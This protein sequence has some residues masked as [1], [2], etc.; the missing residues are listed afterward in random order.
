MT[1]K[2]TIIAYFI[3]IAVFILGVFSLYNNLKP[4]LDEA[5]YAIEKGTTLVLEKGLKKELL[6]ERL[7][8]SGYISDRKDAKFI[9]ARI[10]KYLDIHGE[11][12]NLGS[13]LKDDL[14][15]S[16]DTALLFGGEGLKLRIENDYKNLGITKDYE[17]APK[18]PKFEVKGADGVICVQVVNAKQI[19]DTLSGI[20]IR[21]KHYP[22][23]NTYKYIYQN[24]SKGGKEIVDSVLVDEEV[25]GYAI[26]DVN[27]V[28]TFN[29]KKGEHYSVLPIKKGFQYGR[30]KGTTNGALNEELNLTFVQKPH[31]ISLLSRQTFSNIKYD[32]TLIV[33]SPAKFI[34][35]LV[36]MTIAYI[37]AWALFFIF[38]FYLDKKWET[39]TDYLLIIA[40]MAITG[41][42]LLTIFGIWNP[43]TDTLYGSTT[44]KF[45]LIGVAAMFG[46]MLINYAKLDSKLTYSRWKLFRNY[47]WVAFLVAIGILGMLYLFGSGPD[48]SDAKVKL[49]GIQPSEIVRILIIIF[50]AWFFSRKANLIQSFSQMLTKQTAKRQITVVSW[51]MF[52]IIAIMS[53]YLV[54]SDMGPALVV[55]ISFILIYS[56]ARR[57]FAQLLLGLLSF[58]AVM[59]CARW[60]NNSLPTLLISAAIWFIVWVA[61]WYLK[62]RQIYE[63]AIFLNLVIVVF[64]L[65]GPMLESIGQH[66]LATR[67]TNRT[68]MTW[69]GAWNNEVLGGDQ[70]VQGI[71]SLAT[72]G[73][74]G[75]GLGNGSPSIV[76]AGYTDMI[77]TTIGEMLGFIGI[78]LVVLCFFVIIHRTLLIGR[79]A[80]YTFPFYLAIGVGITTGTQ[81]LVIIAG[82]IGLLPLTGVTLPFLSYGSVSLVMSLISFGFII[83]ISR[84]R[85]SD[86]QKKYTNSFNGSMTACS[87]LFLLI[88]IV[89]LCKSADYQIFSRG[90]TLIRPAYVTNME[91]ARIIEY[92]PRIELVLRKMHAGDIYDRNGV[93]L[94]TSSPSKFDEK[95]DPKDKNS[96]TRLEKCINILGEDFDLK[97]RQQRYYPFGDH[98]LFMLGDYNTRKVFHYYDNN[99]TGYLAEARHIHELRG[100]EIPSK[101]IQLTA[102]E[103]KKN[104]FIEATKDTFDVRLYDYSNLLKAGF[105]DYGIQCNP[106][107]EKHN[108]NRAKRDMTL[109]LD[110]CLQIKLQ[111]EMRDYFTSSNQYKNK[112]KKNVFQNMKLLRASV[113]VLDA[114]HGDLIC[115]A[116]YPLPNQDSIFMLNERKIYGNVP[117]EKMPNHTPITERDLGLTFQTEPGSTAKVMS[118]MAGFM[119][120]GPD[121]SRVTYE[122]R[123]EEIID[124]NSR[125]QLLEPVG[126]NVS[127]KESIVKSS[128]CYFINLVHDKQLYP[129]LDSIYCNTGIRVNPNK[130][131]AEGNIVPYYFYLDEFTEREEF[132]VLIKSLETQAIS[133]YNCY[134]TERSQDNVRKMNFGETQ[135]AWGQGPIL[136]SPL[137]MARVASIVANNGELTPTRYILSIGEKDY[138]VFPSREIISSKSA[139]ILKSYMQA[140]SDK[141]RK[142]YSLPNSAESSNRMGG[143]TGTPERSLPQKFWTRDK[144]SHI[145][146]DA[147]YIFFIESEKL[148]APL[149]I[150]VRFERT[151]DIINGKAGASEFDSGIAVRFVADVVL[152]TL[153][154]LGYKVE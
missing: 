77:F 121:A 103:Y 90:K 21:I 18:T 23:K 80:G 105:L 50:I 97:K 7:Y 19:N 67:L 151:K 37:L 82:S 73:I 33:R 75:L 92:N 126:P 138:P 149:A 115:S 114:E 56:M 78:T 47:G 139:Q 127:M 51:I 128:N 141:H 49:F 129:E 31:V 106:V 12:P 74:D 109:T 120:I 137:N 66:A 113:V 70:V 3:T 26:T 118:A 81:F 52:A 41:I 4:Q 124:I 57:D 148:D 131:Y 152:P 24:K 102:K 1:P 13:L 145:S 14:K 96:P 22:T 62:K 117:F 53:F 36:F 48:G 15:V 45:F 39:R 150:A 76:P 40:L 54:L 2:K 112:N 27:G 63:S 59:L 107:I 43:L 30:E 65:A 8:K 9:A 133:K 72:G 32:R 123:P 95:V 42:G 35:S 140:E 99:P 38:T 116:N 94:A 104:R 25:L 29:V 44:T 64:S 108:K 20:P 34:D 87:A 146:N 136:A 5:E 17:K 134:L 10:T 89:I 68:N 110:A 119:A 147:W 61:Y 111:N 28:A 122:I 132:N 100:L 101:T 84:L 135:A 125:G 86:I 153:N 144:G 154:K 143:K 142:N 58:I 93:L 11:L 85:A 83:S 16:A 6:S 55:L 71:W 130:M 91:G 79:R 60:V 69:D 98:T 88:G 46:V